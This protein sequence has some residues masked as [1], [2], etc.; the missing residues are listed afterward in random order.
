MTGLR[1]SRNFLME[2]ALRKA[3]KPPIKRLTRWRVAR[4]D[5]VELIANPVVSKDVGKQ[6][7]VLRVDRKK[8]RLYVEGIALVSTNGPKAW[9]FSRSASPAWHV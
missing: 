8:N 9:P 1:R 2:L 4:G 5:T 3:P 6:G 7:K